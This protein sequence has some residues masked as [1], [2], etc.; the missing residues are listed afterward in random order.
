MA[1]IRPG[2]SGEYPI[3]QFDVPLALLLER[4]KKVRVRLAQRF[5]C[6]EGSTLHLRGPRCDAATL[7]LDP[8]IGCASIA[9]S[10]VQ[11]LALDRTRQEA[12]REAG[13]S[14]TWVKRNGTKDTC[15]ATESCRGSMMNIGEPR[16]EMRVFS[17]PPSQ[18]HTPPP[19][20][21]CPTATSAHLTAPR[22]ILHLKQHY[23]TDAPNA[24]LTHA[25]PPQDHRSRLARLTLESGRP[26]KLSHSRRKRE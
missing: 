6:C 26:K 3:T 13:A 12:K 2:K 14:E 10:R 24:T 17:P 15:S 9:R 20:P 16:L 8:Y 21:R 4:D 7:N 22:L 25:H 5:N 19:L 23:R 1:L 18:S 11:L